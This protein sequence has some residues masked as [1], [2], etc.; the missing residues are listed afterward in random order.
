[1]ES[2]DFVSNRKIIIGG[3]LNVY[4][5]EK[6]DCL[7][8]HLKIKEK[9]A[10]DLIDVWRIRHPDKQRFTWRQATSAIQRRLD[11]WLISDSCQEE[12]FFY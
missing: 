2:F 6:L 4:F 1:M 10:N 5:N 9:S 7:G 3:D 12:V 8:G 11:Y